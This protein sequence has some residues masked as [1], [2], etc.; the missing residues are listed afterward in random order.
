MTCVCVSV[1]I[2]CVERFIDYILIWD[3]SYGG[4]KKKKIVLYCIV[5]CSS[6]L[7]GY[8]DCFTLAKQNCITCAVE[9]VLILLKRPC[10][11]F[12]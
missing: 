7:R 8:V 12:F 10:R 4:T 2:Y 3:F 9:E 11:V 6:S 1:I 5:V